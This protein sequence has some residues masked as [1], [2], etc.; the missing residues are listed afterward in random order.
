MLYIILVVLNVT[1]FI[2]HKEGENKISY[3]QHNKNNVHKIK[4]MRII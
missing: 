3:V 2:M 1:T 4:L